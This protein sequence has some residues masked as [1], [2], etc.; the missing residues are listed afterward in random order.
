MTP[1]AV[2]IVPGDRVLIGTR[3]VYVQQAY[4][5][6]AWSVEITTV[7]GETVTVAADL[8]HV[9]ETTP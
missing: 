7:T 8:V 9:R 1:A 5:P 3:T 2:L 6:D 4:W